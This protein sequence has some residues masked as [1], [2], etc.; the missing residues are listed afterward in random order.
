MR[1][2]INIV[3]KKTSHPKSHI[4]KTFSY[5]EFVRKNRMQL[6]KREDMLLTN[7]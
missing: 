3:L 6:V 2:L 1:I 5:G 4:L 7:F